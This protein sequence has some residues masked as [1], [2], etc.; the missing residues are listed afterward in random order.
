M[1]PKIQRLRKGRV[2]ARQHRMK[3]PVAEELPRSAAKE[4]A[5]S[6]A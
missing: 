4:T 5:R 2:V 1:L 3:D 6:V